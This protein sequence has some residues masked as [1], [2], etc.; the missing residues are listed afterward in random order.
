[1]TLRADRDVI[2]VHSSDLHIEHDYSRRSLARDGTDVLSAVLTAARK[3]KADV[4]VLAGDTF[5]SHRLPAELVE[6]AAELISAA[7]LPIVLL[8]GNHDP[9]VSNSIFAHRAISGAAN[10]HVI[11]VTHEE[12]VIFDDLELEVWGRAHHGYGDMIPL[13]RP[14]RRSVRWQ[15]AL[16]HGHYVPLPDRATRLRP[17][18][19][20]GDDELAATSADYIALGHWNRPAIVGTVRK[21]YY[22]GS[23]SYAG[24]VNLVRLTEMAGV[25]VQRIKLDVAREPWATD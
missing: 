23:P 10:L 20:I 1:M 13:E 17:S 2:I 19:L 16:A 18:W 21:A 5:D 4:L 24:S 14:R 3:W 15:V 25:E 8:P 12:A 6:R 7:G 9:V 22:C 11:G